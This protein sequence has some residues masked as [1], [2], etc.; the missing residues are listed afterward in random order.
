M[1]YNKTNHKHPFVI[2]LFIYSPV[3]QERAKPRINC[4]HVKTLY[5]KFQMEHCNL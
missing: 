2:L 3:I 1:K 5:A 4:P